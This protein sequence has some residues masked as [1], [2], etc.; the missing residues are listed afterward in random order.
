MAGVGDAVYT[1]GSSSAKSLSRI[2]ILV[3]ELANA[4]F[5]GTPVKVKYRVTFFVERQSLW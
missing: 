5:P 3:V 4:H 2:S 1:W